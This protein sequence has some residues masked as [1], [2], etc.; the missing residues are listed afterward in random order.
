MRTMRRRWCGMSTCIRVGDRILRDY[1]AR[2]N[3]GPLIIV[4]PD[5]D[6]L[7]GI[8]GGSYGDFRWHR[9]ELD[10]LPQFIVPAATRG[11]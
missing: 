5:V 2:G 11:H 8:N 6:M 4:I 9:R 1:V 10:L 7:V 3:G